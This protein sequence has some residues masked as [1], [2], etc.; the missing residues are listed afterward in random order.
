[1]EVKPLASSPVEQPEVIR[2]VA[3]FGGDRNFPI[4]TL[5]S[6]DEGYCLRNLKWIGQS[7]LHI[8]LWPVR[9]VTSWFTSKKPEKKAEE[10]KPP[11]SKEEEIP[12]P[13]P[14]SKRPPAPLH[15]SY[16][17][18]SDRR[19]SYRPPPPPV[20]PSPIPAVSP[21]DPSPIPSAPPLPSV[22][23]TPFEEAMRILQSGIYQRLQSFTFVGGV[24]QEILDAFIALP[25]AF[26][27]QVA[28]FVASFLNADVNEDQGENLQA[29]I[30]LKNSTAL[31]DFLKQNYLWQERLR[32][33]ELALAEV[34]QDMHKNG[35]I[36]PA[37]LKIMSLDVNT[38]ES[39]EI[40]LGEEILRPKLE[41]ILSAV[42]PIVEEYQ[43]R[44]EERIQELQQR[45]RHTWHA[46]R[47][48]PAWLVY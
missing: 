43:K 3:S 33:L 38:S 29:L 10:I 26:Q 8:V 4:S 25:E 48:E 35:L 34:S 21:A 40:L 2:R 32:F 11:P 9:L 47:R 6:G 1:M 20:E 31:L 15:G 23:P 22:P 13:P 41:T 27:R 45:S 24:K 30:R 42:R 18:A 44:K 16:S 37:T 36:L 12:P 46:L 5:S 39:E 14:V 7:I 17:F 28:E 19:F